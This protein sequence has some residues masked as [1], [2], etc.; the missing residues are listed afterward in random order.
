MYESSYEQISLVSPQPMTYSEARH[1]LKFSFCG[2]G[3]YISSLA[4]GKLDGYLDSIQPGNPAEGL[5]INLPIDPILLLHDL[6]KYPNQERIRE[7][8]NG[9]TVL[10]LDQCEDNY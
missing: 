4:S 9:D 1:G 7:L 8:F 5:G 3:H 10:C 2:F 6:G